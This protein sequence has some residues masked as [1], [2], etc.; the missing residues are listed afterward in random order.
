[1]VAFRDKIS[2]RGNEI[3]LASSSSSCY[4]PSIFFLHPILLSISRS[5]TCFCVVGCVGT[6]PLRLQV[7]APICFC[8][9][10]HLSGLSNRRLIWPAL[11]AFSDA[12][13]RLLK[14]FFF[15]IFFYLIVQRRL[16][17]LCH[18]SRLSHNALSGYSDLL[19]GTR[20]PYSYPVVYEA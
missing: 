14:I 18:G 19:T 1:M 15:K 6:R 7:R 11:S 8:F 10:L 12:V 17:P 5:L 9:I 4:A 2:F 3:C 13:P 20:R 16:L